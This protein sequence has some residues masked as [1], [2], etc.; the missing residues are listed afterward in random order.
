MNTFPL[1]TLIPE[2]SLEVSH[3]KEL[4]DSTFPYTEPHTQSNLKSV[5]LLINTPRG[6]KKPLDESE[7][8]E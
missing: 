6:T 4:Q 2:R 7:R 1:F 8:G 5:Y 3:Y